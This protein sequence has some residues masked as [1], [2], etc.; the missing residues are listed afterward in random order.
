LSGALSQIS[1]A[2]KEYIWFKE[3][4]TQGFE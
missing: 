2:I 4:C 3:A 1:K